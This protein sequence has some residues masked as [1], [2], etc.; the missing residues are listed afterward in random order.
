M[1]YLEKKTWTY[2][3]IGLKIYNEDKKPD[4]TNQDR[5]FCRPYMTY[6]SKKCNGNNKFYRYSMRH[7][8]I[9]NKQ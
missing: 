6:C 7:N 4:G 9:S 8:K 3:P 1:F 2:F 5:Y